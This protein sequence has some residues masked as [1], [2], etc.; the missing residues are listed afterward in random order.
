MH[1]LDGF[2]N[3]QG[4]NIKDRRKSSRRKHNIEHGQPLTGSR[5]GNDRR[6]NR[7][8]F[9]VGEQPWW[10]K[11][12]YLDSCNSA[13]DRPINSSQPE[14]ITSESTDYLSQIG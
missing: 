7:G 2:S 9:L 14:R 3:V 12:D 1:H 10:L 11:V 6:K 13:D 5:R 4:R 8:L